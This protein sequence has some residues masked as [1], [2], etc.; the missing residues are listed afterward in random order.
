M[1][2]HIFIYIYFLQELMLRPFANELQQEKTKKNLKRKK[3][4]KP[5]QVPKNKKGKKRTSLLRNSCNSKVIFFIVSGNNNVGGAAIRSDHNATTPDFVKCCQI[6]ISCI[7]CLGCY[8]KN[9]EGTI[10]VKTYYSSM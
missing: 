9:R 5:I 10:T 2:I 1:G 6:Q 8:I 4:L 3:M 7:K